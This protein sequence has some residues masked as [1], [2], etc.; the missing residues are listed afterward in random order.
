M[1]GVTLR[2]VTFATIAVVFRLTAHAENT[3][4]CIW[5]RQ[6]ASVGIIEF[7]YSTDEDGDDAVRGT[8][9][10]VDPA[11]YILTAAH[12]VSPRFNDLT[13]T[14]SETTIR[15]GEKLH[16]EPLLLEEVLRDD[17]IDIALLKI[18]DGGTYRPLSILRELDNIIPGSAMFTIGAPDQLGLSFASG[19]KSARYAVLNNVSLPWWQTDLSLN[20]GNSGGPVFDKN[21]DVVGVAVARKKD[22]QLVSW[23]VP[24]DLFL[25]LAPQGLIFDAADTSPCERDE[26]GALPALTSPIFVNP[27]SDI[28]NQDNGLRIRAIFAEQDIGITQPRVSDVIVANYDDDIKIITEFRVSLVYKPGILMS[29]SRSGPLEPSVVYDIPLKIDPERGDEIFRYNVPASPPLVL[30]PGS[31][32]GP[33]LESFRMR[34]YQSFE[35]AEIKW[36]PSS[37][38]DIQY[39]IEAVDDAGDTVP[40]IASRWFGI[41]HEDHL[42]EMFSE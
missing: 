31:P 7:S 3:A 8:G 10:V 25:T 30:A 34:L 36:H 18:S 42:L 11:G 22:A 9:F 38:W 23:I 27:V 29:T 17:E 1:I 41:E 39:M 40:V 2:V 12:V 21:G 35:N 16:A 15:L 13:V 5:D 32:N 24:I 6:V 4:E 33:G 26:S 19:M 37:G 14:E 20:P 28:Q